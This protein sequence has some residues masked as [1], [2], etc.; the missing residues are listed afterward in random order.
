MWFEAWLFSSGG[1]HDGYFRFQADTFADAEAK[2]KRCAED[3][4]SRMYGDIYIGKI[5]M[6][7][8]CDTIPFSWARG[9]ENV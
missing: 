2:A 8:T 1:L 5:E 7:M 6:K 4:V 9:Q 3:T